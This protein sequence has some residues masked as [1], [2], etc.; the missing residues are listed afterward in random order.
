MNK[1]VLYTFGCSFTENFKFLFKS[2]KFQDDRKTYVIEHLNNKIPDS[3]TELLSKKLNINL[4]NKAGASGHQYENY[5]EG[6]CNMSIFNNICHMCDKFK[7]G[8][9]VIIEWSFIARF[10]WA[11]EQGMITILPNHYRGIDKKLT[12]EIIINRSHKLWINELFIMIKLLNKLSETI[13][14]D[15]Y[16]WTIDNSI[17][18]NKRDLIINDKR[19]L[20]SGQL[21]NK[22]YIDLVCSKNGKSIRTETND[23]IK[24]DHLGVTG[25]N[26]LA[27]LFYEYIIK[28]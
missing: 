4:V 12:E 20:V 18:D 5:F 26:V 15:I 2:S 25:H 13:G 23:K 21:N 8:D 24:D 14:F 9:I 1:P 27:D 17:L 11:T 22:G 16:Y 7:K 10:K 19:W 3:W 6:N 28:K